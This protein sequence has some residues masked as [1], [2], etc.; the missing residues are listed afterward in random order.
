MRKLSEK[1]NKLTDKKNRLNNDMRACYKL[2]LNLT[3][4]LLSIIEITILIT[5]IAILNMISSL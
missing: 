5:V 3:L 1:D 2:G 4:I